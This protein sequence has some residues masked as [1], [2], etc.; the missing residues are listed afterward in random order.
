MSGFVGV[1]SYGL[2]VKTPAAALTSYHPVAGPGA[3]ILLYDGPMSVDGRNTSGQ[4]V[5][6][7]RPRLDIAWRTE[8]KASSF[9]LHDVELTIPHE[10]ETVTVSGHCRGQADGWLSPVQLGQTAANMVRL[11]VPWVNLPAL[12]GT[13]VI[14]DHESTLSGRWQADVGGW[15]VT[16]DRRGDHRDIWAVIKDE[17]ATAVTHVM[18]IRRTDDAAF[19]PEDVDPVLEA[20]HLGMSFA[21]GRWVAPVAPV[22]FDV[23]GRRVWEQWAARVCTAGVPGTLWWW[24]DQDDEHLAELLGL[25]VDRFSEA[26]GRFSARFLLASAIQSAGGGGG[27]VEQR[28]MTATA[29]LEHL[30]WSVLHVDGAMTKEEFEHLKPQGVGKVS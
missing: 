4:I 2:T 1:R 26:G 22:G 20:L 19:T 5:V 16:L 12:R 13:G 17:G 21:V 27:Y 7:L 30:A 11:V 15:T 25:V 6:R 28:I 18:Q 9:D 14:E 10:L 8:G 24:W 3:E 23:A 29:A